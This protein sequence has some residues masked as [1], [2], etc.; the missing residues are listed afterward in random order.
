M[1]KLDFLFLGPQGTGK[2]CIMNILKEK[3]IPSTYLAS[4]TVF[5]KRGTVI[6]FVPKTSLCEV[7]GFHSLDKDRISNIHGAKNICFVINGPE[8]LEEVRNWK[9]GGINSSFLT[10]WYRIILGERQ[11]QDK[12]T[13]DKEKVGHI[14]IIATHNDIYQGGNLDNEIKNAIK[15]A[16]EKYLEEVTGSG[17]PR[18]IFHDAL[19]GAFFAINATNKDEVLDVYHKIKKAR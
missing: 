9:N 6:P 5:D 4:G 7:G 11:K 14:W 2:T 15:V 19:N 18:Y 16:N 10:H 13:K 17:A 1:G 3:S 12:K 8:F